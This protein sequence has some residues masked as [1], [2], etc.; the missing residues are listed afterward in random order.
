MR[1]ATLVLLAVAASTAAAQAP[2]A[3]G[4]AA[5]SGIVRDS[6]GHPITAAEVVV[7]DAGLATTAD[8]A[9]VFHLAGVPAGRTIFTVRHIG[10]DPVSFAIEM[11]ADS[12]VQVQLMLHRAAQVL[13]AI[14]TTGARAGLSAVGFYDR[15][16]ANIGGQYVTPEEIERMGPRSAA[17]AYVQGVRGIRVVYPSRR[18]LSSSTTIYDPS[19]GKPGSPRPIP[20]H[21]GVPVT[22]PA[23]APEGTQI[24]TSGSGCPLRIFVDGI[25]QRASIDDIVSSSEVY[26]VEV[27]ARGTAIPTS[28]QGTLRDRPGCGAVAIWTKKLRPVGSSAAPPDTTKGTP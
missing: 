24:V 6:L 20:A 27:Y 7:E 12:T 25:E 15:M 1:L 17:S 3:A 9:G 16:K 10:Y 23:D 19:S 11:P 21:G 4:K 8:S 2:S 28:F 26:A 18:Q 14:T 13:E 22:G 5:L